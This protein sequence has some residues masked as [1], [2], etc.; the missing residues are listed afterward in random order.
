MVLRRQLTA[1]FCR[2][3]SPWLCDAWRHDPQNTLLEYL[4]PV[5]RMSSMKERGGGGRGQAAAAAAAERVAEHC[6]EDKGVLQDVLENLWRQMTKTTK[7]IEGR[8]ECQR[9]ETCDCDWCRLRRAITNLTS[10]RRQRTARPPQGTPAL[11][12]PHTKRQ[13]QIPYK[14]WVLE[15]TVDWINGHPRYHLRFPRSTESAGGPTQ[16]SVLR[17]LVTSPILAARNG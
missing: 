12:K 11:F 8:P 1:I 17:I 3:H 16:T 9:S 13:V 14:N 6:D 7:N 2:A 15:R 4:K 5:L 10:L